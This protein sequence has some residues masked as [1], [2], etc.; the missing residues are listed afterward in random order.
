M[1]FVDKPKFYDYIEILTN[2][3]SINRGNYQWE[4]PDNHQFLAVFPVNMQR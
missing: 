4:L 3:L 1:T 2:T